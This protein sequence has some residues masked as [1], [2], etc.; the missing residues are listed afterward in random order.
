MAYCQ[1]ASD[2]TH[3][4][5]PVAANVREDRRVENTDMS[6]EGVSP[7]MSRIRLG[8]ELRRH[9]E[10][11]GLTMEALARRMGCSQSKISR[12]ENAERKPNLDDVLDIADALGL[13][14]ADRAV[15][16]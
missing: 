1:L 5:I 15:L 10:A 7:R 11:A 13:D 8:R 6:S 2:M 14:E 9:R 16:G 3:G 12:L 4:A